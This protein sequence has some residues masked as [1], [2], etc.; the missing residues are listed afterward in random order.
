MKISLNWLNDFIDVDQ[1]ADGVA[2]LVHELTMLGL[3]VETQDRITAELE[4]V[5]CA[6]VDAIEA[7]PDAEKL[8]LVTV[9]FG[10]E[11]KLKL[12]CGAPNVYKGMLT[13]LAQLGAR[14]PGFD[15]KPLKKAKIRGVE[16]CGMLCSEVELGLSDNHDGIMDLSSAHWA[17][18]KLAADE[19]A[20]SDVILD[21]EITQNRGDALSIFGVARDLAALRGV[22]LRMPENLPL[23]SSDSDKRAR[24]SI[25]ED[26]AQAGCPRYAGQLLEQVK[27]KPSP[28]WMINR[29]QAVG[30]RPINNVVDITNY[31]MWELGHPLHAFDLRNVKGSEIRVRFAR[32]GEKFVTLDGEER[33]LNNAH[34]L[35]CDAERPVALGGIMGGFNSGVEDDTSELLLECAA[36]DPVNIRMGA[37]LAGLFSDSSRRFERGVDME[38][39][40]QV[41]QRVCS[42]LTQLADARISGGIEDVYP[43][44]R[45]Y[46]QV[47]VRASRL[48]DILGFDLD[49][50][51]IRQHLEALGINCQLVEG[52]NALMAV[53]PGWRFDLDR[54]IDY[55]EE[56]ARMEGYESIRLAN[57]ATIPLKLRNHPFQEFSLR[58]RDKVVGLA[59]NQVKSYSMV[60]PTLL[61]S[62]FPDRPMISI[63]KPL[64]EEMSVLRTSL[65]P[66]MIKT[67][68]YNLNR[69]ND[70]LRL[71]ELDREFHPDENSETGCREVW[72]L[73]MLQSGHSEEADWNSPGREYN[74][75]NIKEAVQSLLAAIGLESYQLEEYADEV[76]SCNSLALKVGRDVIGQFG[77]LN[78]LLCEN[79]GTEQA[80]FAADLDI[81][82]AFK[83]CRKATKYKAYSRFPAVY[84]DLSVI[85]SKQ[86]S[87]GDLLTVIRKNGGKL[88]TDA[89]IFDIYQGEGIPAEEISRSYRLSFSDQA[90]SLTESDVEPI[91]S[92]IVNG[93]KKKHAARLR[94]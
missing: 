64:A 93:L 87:A 84:R 60:D 11:E 13:M 17:A 90:K 5:I 94:D 26:C 30:L 81:E 31:V 83:Y 43:N 37:R 52:E 86:V 19:F 8:R 73:V 50:E 55:I 3:E 59:F 67:A 1:S 85:C 33:T 10:A 47:K 25:D 44:P 40:P 65:L 56:V 79:L 80:L 77:Q 32:D 24:I 9:D 88:L 71:F 70:S 4:G 22:E 23:A 45:Q 75:Y 91:F 63:R 18:G 42:L 7:H 41:M 89:R 54:E 39:I 61:K 20:Y 69:R 16:S 74:F 49:I 28:R 82:L 78:P 36:F 35:I 38:N 12:V 66:S 6:R 15:N 2:S 68:I 72:H 62:C 29:L 46:P 14:L 76:F 48:N 53:S 34:T 58:I 92:K 57:R 21:I 27:V 51:R